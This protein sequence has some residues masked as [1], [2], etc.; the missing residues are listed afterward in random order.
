M[1][2]YILNEKSQSKLQSEKQEKLKDL[3][4][5]INEINQQ[6]YLLKRTIIELRADADKAVQSAEEKK[7]PSKMLSLL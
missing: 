2:F 7:Q 4:D 5:D 1:L 3:N 6:T